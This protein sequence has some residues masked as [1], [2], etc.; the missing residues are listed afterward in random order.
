MY[1]RNHCSA[2]I[3][4]HQ[5]D[6]WHVLAGCHTYKLAL[7]AMPVRADERQGSEEERVETDRGAEVCKAWR[8]YWRSWNGCH[9]CR[10]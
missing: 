9:F 2:D 4:C 10:A 3:V 5:V 1:V 8:H 6:P 7:R